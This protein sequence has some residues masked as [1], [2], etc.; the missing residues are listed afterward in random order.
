MSFRIKT[1]ATM[2]GIPRATIVAWERRYNLLEPRR[3]PAGYRIYSDEDVEVLRRVKRM[4]E[5]GYAI[6]EALRLMGRVMPTPSASVEV[7]EVLSGVARELYGAMLDFDRAAADRILGRLPQSFEQALEEVY[8]PVLREIGDGWEAGRVS[9]AQEH[10]ATAFC[11]ERLQLMFQNLGAGPQDGPT[12]TCATPPGERHELALLALA[13]RLSLRGMKVTWLGADMPLEAMVA[14]LESRSPRML[15][16]TAMQPTNA[17]AVVAYARALRQG[18]PA[19][20]LIV[21]GGP[22]VDGVEEPEG[23]WL[24]ATLEDLWGRWTERARASR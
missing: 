18:A 10:F 19:N 14:Y 24:C 23:V 20:T 11:R 22:G 3:S 9:I 2:T 1:V 6:S 8:L 15:C 12:V 5:E 16:L 7:P 17:D 4:T 21:V 13:V